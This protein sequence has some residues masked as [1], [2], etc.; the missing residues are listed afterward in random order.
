[1]CGEHREPRLEPVP[2]RLPLPPAKLQGSLYENQKGMKNRY[3]AVPTEARAAR[4]GEMNDAVSVAPPVVDST[5]DST[6]PPFG[7]GPPDPI[8]YDGSARAL[9]QRT[10]NFAAKR[11]RRHAVCQLAWT[12]HRRSGI[13][14]GVH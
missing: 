5:F 11:L 2:V 14:A 6:R 10:V 8:V 4:A 1:M 12:A 7:D 3:F 13:S 9:R